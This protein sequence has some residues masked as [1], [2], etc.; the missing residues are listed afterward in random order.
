MVRDAEAS[1]GDYLGMVVSGIP[2]EG[3]I[4]VVQNVL[5]QLKMAIDMYA[6]PSHRVDYLD[7]LATA[8]WDWARAAEAGSDRQLAFVRSFTGAASTPE[9]LDLVAGLLSGATVLD[10]LAVDTDLRWSL[11]QRLAATG[12]ADGAA[13]DA[14]LARDDTATGR[15]QA[16]L[17]MAARPDA[18][19]KAA[20]WTDL[21]ERDDLPNAVLEATIAGFMQFGQAD[22]LTPYRDRYFEALPRIWE[23]RTSEMAQDLTMGLYPAILVDAATLSATDAFLAGTSL[24]SA[25]VRLV[26]E[27]RDGVARALRCQAR[28]R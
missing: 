25:A 12:R 26:S 19:A 23:Q 4:G 27:G 28:D 7:R 24:K 11:L 16:A 3:D 13:I 14:E 20:A 15:R 22:V 8:T 6:D 1:A 9:H 18:A 21:V 2:G 5:R 10:G 17:A